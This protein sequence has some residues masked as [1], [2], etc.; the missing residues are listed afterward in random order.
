MQLIVNKF[1]IF[2]RS[3]GEQKWA[4]IQS[5]SILEKIKL[6]ETSKVL[7]IRTCT[8]GCSTS[9]E[10]SLKGRNHQNG[11]TPSTNLCAYSQPFS[12]DAKL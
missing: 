7:G 6:V 11:H 5:Y 1:V 10:V 4:P 2:D 12:N 3:W 8:A 9:D